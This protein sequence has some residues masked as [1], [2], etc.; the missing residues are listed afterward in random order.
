MLRI[1]ISRGLWIFGV[2]QVL[3]VP[4]FALLTHFPRTS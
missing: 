2:V 4:G 3:A 1:G